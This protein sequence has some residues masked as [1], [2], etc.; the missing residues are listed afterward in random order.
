MKKQSIS[1]IGI[2]D[3]DKVEFKG[4]QI[5]IFVPIVAFNDELGELLDTL[6]KDF[7][8]KHPEANE[9]ISVDVSIVYSFG[10]WANAE[11]ELE[12]IM[13]DPKDEEVEED[14]TEIK[15]NPSEQAIRNIKKIIW[16][17]MG[18]MLGL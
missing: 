16:N 17:K 4:G 10:L 12:I 2:I 11:Y 18:E 1:N 15:I 3:I 9:E 14:Y 13:F 8:K 7:R 5:I 6:E